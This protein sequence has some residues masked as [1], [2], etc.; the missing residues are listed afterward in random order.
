MLSHKMK[1]LVMEVVRMSTNFDSQLEKTFSEDIE[2]P[3]SIIDKKEKAFTEIRSMAKKDKVS[4]KRKI[5]SAVAAMF[6]IGSTFIA[7]DAFATIGGKTISAIKTI[8]FKDEGVQKAIDNGLVQNLS[9]ANIVKNKGIE[10]GVT[11]ITYDSS[12]LAL[13]LDIKFDDKSLLNNLQEIEFDMNLKDNN[14]RYLIK[15]STENLNEEQQKTLKQ[16]KADFDS[17][18]VINKETGEIKY[19]LVLNSMEPISGIDNV[20]LDIKA[21]RLLASTND[22]LQENIFSEAESKIEEYE[23]YNYKQRNLRLYNLIE[24]KWQTSITLDKKFKDG[25]EVLYVPEGLNGETIK[26]TKAELLPTCMYVTLEFDSDFKGEDRKKII[27]KIDQ[28]T[29]VDDNGN[30]HNSTLKGY[31]TGDDNGHLLKV[32][33]FEITSFDYDG[34]FKVILNDFNSENKVINLIKKS[35]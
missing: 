1:A 20:N 28:A 7:T 23:K 29:L 32:K 8:F 19:N 27:N 2:I 30:V 4:Q 34:N 3:K 21:V 31:F 6:I 16:L 25:K 13:S 10:I 15:S 5:I 26:V 35:K 18:K 12:K 24:G 9:N 11:D 22:N 17:N 14:G 33:S